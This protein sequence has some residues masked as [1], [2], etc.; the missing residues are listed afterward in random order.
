MRKIDV[1][2]SSEEEKKNFVMECEHDFEKRLCEVSA[3]AVKECSKVLLLS[4]PTCAG[5][6]TL[7]KK[8]ISDFEKIG[9]RVIVVSIDDFFKDRLE[10]RAV[11]DDTKI[12]YD[13]V[14]V[15]DLPELEKCVHRALHEDKMVVPI[16]DFISQSRIGYNEYEIGK[17]DIIIFEGIQAVYPE[18]LKLFEKEEKVGIFINV[19]CDIEVNGVHFC[20]DDIRL[21]RR[22]VRD[23]KFR[24]A[25]PE[26]TL[27]LWDSV[28]ENEDK[29]IYPNKNVCEIQI[30]SLMGYELFVLKKYILEIL[31]EVKEDSKYYNKARELAEKFEKFQEISYEY[32][33]KNSLYTE[34]LGKK[35]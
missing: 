4:G 10:V 15:I 34:F 6:T 7:A 33:P 12:D 19:D 16:F 3:K 26:F 20:R 8:I 32:V 31:K 24:G 18:V 27:Y 11:N 29:S 1:L 5:K 22:L 17:F 2:F 13:S 25:S 35:D 28:R 30:N 23:Y 21:S 14:D 9:R